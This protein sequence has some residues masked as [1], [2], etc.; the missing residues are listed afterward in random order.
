MERQHITLDG[1]SFGWGWIVAFFLFWS[2]GGWQRVDCAIG[3]KPACDVVTAWYGD[4]R[5]IVLP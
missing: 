1:P 2:C 4:P 5:R 3:V